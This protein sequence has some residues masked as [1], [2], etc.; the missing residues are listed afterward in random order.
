MLQLFDAPDANQ[1]LGRRSSTTV[2]P[3][4]LL[5]MNSPLVWEQAGVWT[6][7][8]LAAPEQS[9]EA[10][11]TGMYH[12]A[13]G[14]EPAREELEAALEFLREQA[15]QYGD[16]DPKRVWTDLAHVLFNTKE[17]VYVQ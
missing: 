11:I 15:A 9:A 10:R 1:G 8:V 5:A 6:K 4:A 14:R 17:F 7:Q 13:L 2:A 3:Q 12:R 16:T